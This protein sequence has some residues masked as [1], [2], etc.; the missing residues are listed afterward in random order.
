MMRAVTIGIRVGRRDASFM[1]IKPPMPYF[2]VH[3]VNDAF[4][5]LIVPRTESFG[6]IV[7]QFY[8]DDVLDTRKRYK[9]FAVM[10]STTVL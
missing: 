5:K 1:G 10:T 8:V 7:G 9:Q 6:C 3:P 4:T 2:S